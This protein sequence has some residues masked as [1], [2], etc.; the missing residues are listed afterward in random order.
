MIGATTIARIAAPTFPR[1]DRFDESCSGAVTSSPNIARNRSV[2]TAPTISATTMYSTIPS[3]Y[4]VA[5]AR[6]RAPTGGIQ[7]VRNQPGCRRCSHAARPTTVTRS[8]TIVSATAGPSAAPVVRSI[9]EDRDEHASHD[10]LRE[11]DAHDDVGEH[12]LPDGP[13]DG[14]AELVDGGRAERHRVEV[15]AG[16]RLRHHR[17]HIIPAGRRNGISGR[18][19]ATTRSRRTTAPSAPSLASKSS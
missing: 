18:P 14:R 9:D 8:T 11:H 15:R 3:P 2:S 19:S 13:R 6:N 7:R 12:G 10:R 17:R 5:N 16:G 4:P 1:A